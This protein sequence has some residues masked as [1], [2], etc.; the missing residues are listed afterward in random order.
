MKRSLITALAALLLAGTIFAGGIVT[1]TNQS[2]MYTRMAAR[3]ATLG[4]DA[5]YYNPAGLTKLGKGFHFSINNQTIGQTRTITS[6][7]QPLNDGKYTGEV[8]APIFPGVYAVFNM[9]KLA[10][11]AGFNP[12]G[13]GGGATY[14]RGLPSFEYSP[15]D[16]PTALVN[17]LIG[18]TVDGYSIDAFFEGSS[19]FFGY[20]ANVSYKI[21]DMISVAVGVR[22]VSAKETYKGHLND[23]T[24]LGLNNVTLPVAIDIT[25]QN[26]FLNAAA[27]AQGGY[28]DL[29]TDITDGTILAGD[30]LSNP[31][32]IQTLTVMGLYTPG[33]SNGAAAATYAGA[34]GQYTVTSN[35]LASQ[36]VDA[37]KTASGFT[38]IVSV[39]IQPIEMLNVAVKY[40]HLTKLEFTNK[41]VAGKEGTVGFDASTGQYVTLFP[42]DAKTNLDM[43]AL[44]S[45]GA[46][47]RPIDALLIATGFTSYFDKNANW[48]G[49][50][51]LLDGN[52]WDVAIGAEY[53]FGE[54]LLASASWSMTQTGA[55][56]AYQSDLSYSLPTSGISFG[57]GYNIIESLQVNLGVQLVN[58]TSGERNFQ[59]DFANAGVMMPV[60]ETYEKAV[61]VVGA[62][63]NY[64]LSTGE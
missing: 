52:S 1:N 35:L 53:S 25:G 27:S 40:E 23:M 56:E 7:Y 32:H 49:R 16:L 22:Y 30:P 55:Q 64:S 28:V 6:N 31:T 47:L 61:W 54:K 26:Y 3:H 17:P 20:Q 37:E 57:I 8:S 41:T 46:T 33:M 42:N 15:S 39:N 11:S 14:N 21:N 13:G 29:N 48:D 4:I 44:L 50:E 62:G 45:I 12:I 60:K 5:V 10:F 38:P 9:G 58:Y 2:A 59:H 43:P 34:A 19:I 63:I 51:E 36:D 18:Q 24:L